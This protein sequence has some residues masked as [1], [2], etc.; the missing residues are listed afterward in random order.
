MRIEMRWD[1]MA[2]RVC[3]WCE[4][5]SSIARGMRVRWLT[6][7]ASSSGTGVKSRRSGPSFS[8]TSRPSNSSLDMCG[9]W[10]VAS[11]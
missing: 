1:G 4:Q 7:R 6:A 10:L 9:T 5:V 11:R 8:T 2:D 3:C